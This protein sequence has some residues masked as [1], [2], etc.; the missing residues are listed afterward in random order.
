[1]L[2]LLKTLCSLK[3]HIE[4]QQTASEPRVTSQ[5]PLPLHLPLK[6]QRADLGVRDGK[7]VPGCA[8]MDLFIQGSYL[9]PWMGKGKTGRRQ[10]LL[11]LHA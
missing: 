11:L 8:V 3:E 6:H 10:R 5:P 7:G 2:N 1:M 9:K 4:T